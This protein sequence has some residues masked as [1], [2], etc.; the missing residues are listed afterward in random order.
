MHK[1]IVFTI[2]GEPQGKAR[3]R[4]F[5]KGNRTITMT[6]DKTVLYENL[7]KIEYRR[8]CNTYIDGPVSI[9]IEAYFKIPASY[10]KKK[11]LECINNNIYPTK[12]PDF[13]NIAKVVCD[14]LNQIAYKDDSY[15]VNSEFRKRWTEEN[16]GYVIV[17]LQKV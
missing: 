11:R 17:Y 16:E 12:K 7:I 15:I 13:D 4:T 8:Q 5:N 10:S 2:P 3:A 9:V 1:A 14:S 6:T